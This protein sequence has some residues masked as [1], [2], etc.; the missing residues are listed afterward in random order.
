MKEINAYKVLRSVDNLLGLSE[1]LSDLLVRFAV[2]FVD[3]RLSGLSTIVT[4]CDSGAVERTRRDQHRSQ[5]S[6]ESPKE[7]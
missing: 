2:G 4:D 6:L 3:G 7:I 5:S 1:R